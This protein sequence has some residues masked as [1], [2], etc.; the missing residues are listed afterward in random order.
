MFEKA[1]VIYA[2]TRK[3]AIEDGVLI[4]VTDTARE[5]GFR[6]PVALTLAVWCDYVKVPKGVSGQDES[7]RLWDILTMLTFAARKSRGESEIRFRLHVRND[8]RERT[9]PLIELKAVCGPND[10]GSPCVTVMQPSED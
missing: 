7:G 3:Q 9:P 6:Y 1:N 2:Y 8:N 10:D 5:A 4:D